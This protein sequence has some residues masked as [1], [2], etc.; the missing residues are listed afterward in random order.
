MRH[1]R[2][3]VFQF[4]EIIRKYYATDPL[5]V[6][7]DAY[8]AIDQMTNLCGNAGETDILRD[9]LKE[10]L[11]IDLLLIAGAQSGSRLLADNRNDGNVVHFGVVQTI[12]QMDRAR[13]G[14]SK[15][16]PGR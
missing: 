13:P 7:R 15:A 11:E 16:R 14:G 10:I 3:F 9:I 12:E 5:F 4:L 2:V 6:V 8:R 1:R